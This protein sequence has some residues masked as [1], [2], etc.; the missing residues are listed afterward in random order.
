[1]NGRFIVI[2][3]KP[4]PYVYGTFRSPEEARDW[5]YKNVVGYDYI[6]DVLYSVTKQ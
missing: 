5:A 1:M 3:T 4:Q 2:V 6:V